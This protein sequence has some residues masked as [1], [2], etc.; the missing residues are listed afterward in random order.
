MTQKYVVPSVSAGLLQLARLKSGLSQAKLAE[1]V[2][3]APTMISAYERDLRQPTLPTLLRLL[4]AAGFDLR[5]HLAPLDSHDQ[6]VAELEEARTDDER[7]DRDQ[8]LKAW[9]QA[10][11]VGSPA[12]VE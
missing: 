12:S 1:K 5:M 3:V 8:Q 9:R 2:G 7:H 6:V 4:H 11:P 10:V